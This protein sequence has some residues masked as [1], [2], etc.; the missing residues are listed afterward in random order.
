M[1]NAVDT[2]MKQWTELASKKEA[3]QEDYWIDTPFGSFKNPKFTPS[4]SEFENE[5]NIT[6]EYD[7]WKKIEIE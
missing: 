6:I 7:E 3:P 1:S 2:W 5:L 4:E